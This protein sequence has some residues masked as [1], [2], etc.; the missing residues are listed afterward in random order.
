MNKIFLILL[1]VFCVSEIFAEPKFG[2][3]KDP[4]DGS[5]Y[6]TVKIGNQEWFAEN[7]NYKKTLESRCYEKKKENCRKYG[8]LYSWSDAFEYACPTGWH[9]PTRADFKSLLNVVSNGNPKD[10]GGILKSR[11]ADA[12]S[13]DDYGFSVLLA[14]YIN[15]NDAAIGEAAYFWLSSFDQGNNPNHYYAKF[16]QYEN[17]VVV[18]SSIGSSSYQF[19][20]VRCVKD[21]PQKEIKYEKFTDERDGTVYKSV[22]IGTQ[23][24]MAE[25]LNY[26]TEE[27]HC[28]KSKRANCAK[29]GRLY[30][31]NEARNACP[32]GWVLPKLVDFEEL[33]RE[34]GGKDMYAA[35]RLKSEKN[36]KHGYDLFG[37]AALPA[38]YGDKGYS[39]WD[40][41]D[42]GKVT[43]F[44]SFTESGSGQ[45][46]SMRLKDWSENGIEK[47]D[48]YNRSKKQGFSI[49]CIKGG[50]YFVEGEMV[51]DRDE[52]KYKTVKIE[53][54]TWMAE[55]L[56]F[57]TKNSYC[58]ND[59]IELCAKYG[60][61]YEW[62]IA[63]KA[64]PMGWHLP[65]QKEYETLIASVGGK[66][67][68]GVSLKSTSNWVVNFAGDNSGS[69]A[70]SFKALS[71]GYGN[72]SQ[73]R[74]ITF[75]GINSFGYFW[76]STEV[77]ND[78]YNA[79]CMYLDKHN[80]EASIESSVYKE[81]ACSVRCIKDSE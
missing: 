50:P 10:A 70:Y 1:V 31:W 79:Y 5:K 73:G 80:D 21:F 20:S 37:F 44:W 19:M 66:E 42:S 47:I 56:N 13:T 45:A 26:N 65:T 54:Q 11:N 6:K 69:D 72:K 23:T 61:L 64:C 48:L 32:T 25:N 36:W 78:K 55:N 76:S 53:K 62:K 16:S 15:G 22:Q 77:E 30:N 8:R 9:L 12:S 40:F 33:I 63:L 7:A 34:A 81:Y 71:A 51:D 39:D 58:Y 24:W 59:S 41:R 27:S 49:R 67:I 52:K 68:A 3:M 18:K 35:E 74:N 14:G 43:E 60:R 29:Y 38:G 4:R 75:E 2:L 17:D 46:Y 57:E 28:Y